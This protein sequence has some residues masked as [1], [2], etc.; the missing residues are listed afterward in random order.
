MNTP[1][2]NSSVTL[3]A[4]NVG[5]TGTLISPTRVMTAN[6]C[7]GGDADFGLKADAA[8][9]GSNA[10]V[11]VGFGRDPSNPMA[12]VPNGYDT[13]T[14]ASLPFPAV[15]VNGQIDLPDQ[16]SEDIAILTLSRLPVLT[17]WNVTPVHPFE[18]DPTQPLSAGGAIN[19]TLRCDG[20]FFGIFSGYGNGCSA[21]PSR[22]ANGSTIHCDTNAM[23]KAWWDPTKYHGT[24]QGD[25]GGP[26]F[27]PF[28][29]QVNGTG[30]LVCGVD[31][32]QGPDVVACGNFSEFGTCLAECLATDNG[33]TPCILKAAFWAPTNTQG[34]DFFIFH[35]AYDYKHNQWMGECNRPGI[36]EDTDLDGVDDRCDNCVGQY[37][38]FQED[39]D[40]DGVG[41]ICD[42]C[43]LIPNPDQADSNFSDEKVN[44]GPPVDSVSPSATPPGTP[45]TV[46]YLTDN[47]PGDVCDANPIAAIQ[48][49]LYNYAEPL[50]R[51]LPCTTV[52]ACGTTPPGPST[53]FAG[54]SNSF[55]VDAFVG[56]LSTT[57]SVFANKAAL[58]RASACRCP[59]ADTNPSA[60]NNPVFGCGREPPGTTPDNPGS[61]WFG[62][63]VADITNGNVPSP[64]INFFP[65]DP[66]PNRKGLVPTVHNDLSKAG[67]SANPIDWGWAYWNDLG[68]PATLTPTLDPAGNGYTGTSTATD[69]PREMFHGLVWTW[70]RNSENA[71]AVDQL[72]PESTMAA[73][74]PDGT[75]TSA[76]LLRQS[77]AAARVI[78]SIP[79]VVV[80]Q[81]PP[82][83]GLGLFRLPD[84]LAC[85]ACAGAA[86][87]YSSDPSDPA[88]SVSVVTPG[89][90]AQ[91]N[92]AL[93]PTDVLHEIFNP[94][95][96]LLMA[97]DLAEWSSGPRRGVI[98]NRQ[99]H[100]IVD[101]LRGAGGGG[102]V[103]ELSGEIDPPP[104][105]DPPLVA[106][107]SGHRQEVAFFGERDAQNRPLNGVRTYDFD[108][109]Q[110]IVW[111]I[112]GKETLH[113]P[114]A[115][116]YR[117]QDDA[118]WLLDRVQARD[119][120]TMR[121][122][123]AQRGVVIQVIA[124]WE[125]HR[126]HTNF[127]LTTG[128]EGSL[129]ISASRRER[130]AIAVL[131]VD[132]LTPALTALYFGRDPI[133]LSAYKSLDGVT[134][135]TQAKDGSV[136]P[137]RQ[138]ETRRHEA[139]LEDD[140]SGKGLEL[141]ELRKIF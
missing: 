58:T 24:D 130:H 88:P 34:N 21:Q 114:V 118:Y 112:V 106:A 11:T 107:V 44:L 68:I 12:G 36:P 119:G 37:N 4:N 77:V 128:A 13:N 97:S 56:S 117:P 103:G 10:V 96:A 27:E 45:R 51:S 91:N 28:S 52:G 80:A 136:V 64:H 6:H 17:A 38:P 134:F 41:D 72:H 105:A 33:A 74:P 111:P 126:H 31:S 124:Q 86:I 14:V 122:V 20:D 30:L 5:C 95:N 75:G 116:T 1:A 73:L 138:L 50:M 90:L 8:G 140:R 63:T 92:V 18:V 39:A 65:T 113:D 133:V 35:N 54:I 81:C 108:L 87:A 71:I 43:Q 55:H 26:L 131:S 85:P 69:N 48:Q 109:G 89:V 42:N 132:G 16:A 141:R 123:R 101:I 49:G 129:V 47:Y 93:V 32:R 25:S 84:V 22:C 139:D 125:S 70:I 127:E 94:Q 120:E 15:H 57:P 76:V 78:E 99:S 110:T 100:A 29:P 137:Q 7:V 82:S 62:M 115:V 19:T 61:G 60:C 83:P 104:M 79:E 102:V 135:A 23:C 40:G 2:R 3:G 59:F 53:C 121:L 46:T 98:V 67:V 9:W 66:N